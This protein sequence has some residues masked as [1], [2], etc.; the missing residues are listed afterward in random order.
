[1]SPSTDRALYGADPNSLLAG[2]PVLRQLRR[3]LL[4][5]F[6]GMLI[7]AGILTIAIAWCGL[8]EGEAWALVALG[9]VGLA[10]LPCWWLVLRPYRGA[11]IRLKLGDLP[12]FMW[13]PAAVLVPGVILGSIPLW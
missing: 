7:S 6:A 10:V 13:I 1:M 3:T 5:M 12:P 4:H 11:G 9:V 2:D 8:R